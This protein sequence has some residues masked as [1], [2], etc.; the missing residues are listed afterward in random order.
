MAWVFFSPRIQNE[1]H[2]AT[3]LSATTPSYFV[4]STNFTVVLPLT[5]MAPADT[6][7][8]SNSYFMTRSDLFHQPPP[9]NFIL[10]FDPSP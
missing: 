6:A 4:L 9:G 2:D 8:R 10:D 1:A 3:G 7:G 5:V